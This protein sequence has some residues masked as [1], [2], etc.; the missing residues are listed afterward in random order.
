MESIEVFLKNFLDSDH[1][2][3]VIKG[4]WGVGKTHY[5]NSFY[6]KHSKKLDF[7]AYSYD[8]SYFQWFTILVFL[9][10][11]MLHLRSQSKIYMHSTIC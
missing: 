5:W 10:L 6:T 2:V 8:W 7:N 1:R 4:N 11:I 3:A 9:A